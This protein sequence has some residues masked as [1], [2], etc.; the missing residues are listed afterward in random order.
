MIST[1]P[2]QHGV[3]VCVSPLSMF[4]DS[5]C[6]KV[7]DQRCL[8]TLLDHQVPRWVIN[9][10]PTLGVATLERV[11]DESQ[12]DRTWGVTLMCRPN[13]VEETVARVDVNRARR[14]VTR[15]SMGDTNRLLPDQDEIPHAK[16]VAAPA[17]GQGFA[18][19]SQRRA[20][21]ADLRRAAENRGW[22]IVLK[23]R[24]ASWYYTNGRAN[25]WSKD[26]ALLTISHGVRSP[27]NMMAEWA[28][29]ETYQTWCFNQGVDP[30]GSEEGLGPSLRVLEDYVEHLYANLR[31]QI[32]GRPCTK[33]RGKTVIR[34][35][36]GSLRY[37]KRYLGLVALPSG[38]S[39]IEA[40]AAAGELEFGSL[41]DQATPLPREAIIHLEKVVRGEEPRA[42]IPDRY[43][44]GVCLF[45]VYSSRR[46]PDV[47]RTATQALKSLGAAP[48]TGWG[49]KAGIDVAKYT[50]VSKAEFFYAEWIPTFLSMI[51]NENLD[52]ILPVPAD[53]FAS[54]AIGTA[55][56]LQR[57]LT[58]TETKQWTRRLFLLPL[59]KASVPNEGRKRIAR[60]PRTYAF[61]RTMPLMVA[62]AGGQVDDVNLLM[63]H[64]TMSQSRA[65]VD[66][67]GAQQLAIKRAAIGHA[68]SAAGNACAA[69]SSG[70]FKDRGRWSH[71]LAGRSAH[72]FLRS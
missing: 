64:K 44:A 61:R 11:L 29:L 26:R 71:C 38:M 6:L 16:R 59:A 54:W 33:R 7:M 45:C 49:T 42:S 67:A 58:T 53:D 72:N 34:S 2:L 36:L 9:I 24:N 3:V 56:V 51:P 15:I 19:F 20:G 13:T 57:A 4:S 27:Q 37:A 22:A 23:M 41:P 46:F 50:S 66:A 10:P 21:E 8:H 12:I 52:F 17:A 25:I 47:Q 65:Y 35:F 40:R 55:E 32:E 60:A 28:R 63:L 18:F 48:I 39:Y 5:Q 62:S 30:W 68:N 1:S 43:F 70:S 31:A 14:A 69:T